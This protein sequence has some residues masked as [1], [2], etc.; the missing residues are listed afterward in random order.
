MHIS[1]WIMIGAVLLAPV[2]AIQVQKFIE[3]YKEKR[4]RR[5]AIF[6]TLMAT[7]ATAMAPQHVEALNMIDIEFYGI[8]KIT[9]AWKVYLDH[10]G[11]YPKPD[12]TDYTAKLDACTKKSQDLLVD[13]LH[14]MSKELNYNFDKV[15]LRR[16]VYIPQGHAEIEFEQNVIRRSMVD[17]FLGNKTFPVTIKE[18]PPVPPQ[19]AQP[20]SQESSQTEIESD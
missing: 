10:L 20:E 19:P 18:L 8:N 7:R 9:D 12:E 15:H 4:G 3:N 16:A 14:E 2:I 1:D 17:M 11:S 6:R 13:L 5:L